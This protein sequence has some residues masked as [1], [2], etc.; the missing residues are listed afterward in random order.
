MSGWVV[1]WMEVNSKVSN[2][3]QPTAG[4]PSLFHH[5]WGRGRGWA[6]P[7]EGDVPGA[8]A[9]SCG[10]YLDMNLSMAKYEAQIFYKEVLCCLHPEN[11]EYQP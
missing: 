2:H 6:P 1:R 9:R 4:A 5:P 7:A 8:D 10:N 3:S 11:L